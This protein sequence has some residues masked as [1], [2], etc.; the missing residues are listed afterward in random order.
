MCKKAAKKGIAAIRK[1]DLQWMANVSYK[2]IDT[3]ALFIQFLQDLDAL[4]FDHIIGIDTE[5]TGLFPLEDKI[6][7]S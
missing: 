3:P 1:K 4:P 6:S 7:R 2:L 5:T